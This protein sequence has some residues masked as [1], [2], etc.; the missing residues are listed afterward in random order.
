M[1][2]KATVHKS[3]LTTSRKCVSSTSRIAEGFQSLESTLLGVMKHEEQTQ[4]ANR[5]M[6]IF[7]GFSPKEGGQN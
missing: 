2:D 6:Q 7:L 5:K 4:G 3:D 1:S